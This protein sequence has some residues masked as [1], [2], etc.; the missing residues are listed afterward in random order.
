ME[1]KN[2]VS[3]VFKNRPN[4]FI[5][6]CVIDNEEVVVHVKNTGRCKELLIKNANVF[7]EYFPDTLRK[8]KFDLI[9]VYKGERL[10]NMDSQVPN[11]VV[12]EAVN[13]G[14]NIL[15]LDN[16][17]TYIKMEQKYKQSRF[18]IYAESNNNKIFIEVKGVTLEENNIAM[19]PDAPTERG[20][21]HIHELVD[22][23]ENGYMA[24]IIFVIQM[25]NVKYFTPNYKTHK[26]FG[27]ALK[28]ASSKGVKILAY[29]CIISKDSI[30][31]NNQVDIKL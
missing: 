29:D 25:E 26:E 5:A 23:Y 20:I 11:K 14:K 10:I 9:S 22:A 24:Y 18:D 15:S 19:F 1:Y 30:T 3:A 27:E 17:I 4:R 2:I 8:T 21:K 31:L 28:Y 7:L 16:P 13:G 6:E 12:Y